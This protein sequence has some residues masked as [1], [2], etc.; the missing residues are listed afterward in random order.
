[1]IR[2]VA[3][4][5]ALWYFLPAMGLILL[6]STAVFVVLVRRWTVLRDQTQLSL[7]AR[8]SDYR[9][10]RP[11]ADRLVALI[12]APLRLRARINLAFCR[13]ATWLIRLMPADASP[14]PRHLLLRQLSMNWPATAL[15]PPVGESGLIDPFSLRHFPA[16]STPNRFGV[17]ATTAASARALAS[18]SVLGLL[19]PDLGLLL[20]EGV[21]LLDF[22]ARPFDPIELDRLAVLVDQLVQHLPVA[23]AAGA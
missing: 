11:P 18:S 22:S 3:P 17:Y 6:A 16:F 15:R 19:P 13:E 20:Y 9:L 8:E 10:V 12:P 14:A 2:L 21:L 23:L 1:M 4:V 7:W 5:L